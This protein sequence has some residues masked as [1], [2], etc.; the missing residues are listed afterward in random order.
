VANGL[1]RYNRGIFDE[2]YQPG[3]TGYE[4]EVAAVEQDALAQAERDREA[5]SE[6][7]KALRRGALGLRAD[8]AAFQAIPDLLVGD[9]EEAAED[10]GEAQ[11]LQAR[12]AQ[13]TPEVS[14][15]DDVNSVGDAA[16]LLVNTLAEQAPNLVGITTGAGALAVGARVGLRKTVRGVASEVTARTLPLATRLA[17][18]TATEASELAGTLAARKLAQERLTAAAGRG[19]L[20]VAYPTL[21]G[22]NLLAAAPDAEDPA[23]L[24]Q[25][26]GGALLTAAPQAI[27]ETAL[28]MRVLKNLGL[29]RGAEAAVRGAASPALLRRVATETA[30]GAL[31]EGTTELAQQA[32]QRGMRS[33]L[34]DNISAFDD[35]AL[36]EYLDSFVLGAIGGGGFGGLSVLGG[37][38]LDKVLG[39]RGSITERYE[40]IL[41][42]QE[43]TVRESQDQFSPGDVATILDRVLLPRSPL[44]QDTEL[45]RVLAEYASSP[46]RRVPDDIKFVKDLLRGQVRPEF[47]DKLDNIADLV[48][49]TSFDLYEGREDVDQEVEDTVFETEDPRA[50]GTREA[51]ER[52]IVGATRL[53]TDKNLPAG[54]RTGEVVELDAPLKD[55]LLQSVKL[56]NRIQELKGT[57]KKFD[58]AAVDRRVDEAVTEEERREGR[59][60]RDTSVGTRLDLANLNAQL[61]EATD[62]TKR[63]E[64]KAQI[65]ELAK[66]VPAEDQGVAARVEKI[67]GGDFIRGWARARGIE[68]QQAA[69]DFV[70]SKGADVQRVLKEDY[71]GDALKMLDDGH[72]EAVAIERSPL[73]EAPGVTPER[74]EEL[75]TKRAEFRSRNPAPQPGDISFKFRNKPVTIDFKELVADAMRNADLGRE[76]DNDFIV[77]LAD[78]VGEAMGNLATT[79]GIPN[80]D[81]KAILEKLPDNLVVL[82]RKG[83]GI[84]YGDLKEGVK[85]ASNADV[86]EDQATRRQIT[87]LQSQLE[88]L[89]QT[90]GNNAM[91]I[92]GIEVEIERLTEKLKAKPPIEKAQVSGEGIDSGEARREPMEERRGAARAVQG[93]RTTAEPILQEQPEQR[94]ENIDRRG[95]AK[96]TAKYLREAVAR[97]KKASR[98]PKLSDRERHDTEVKIEE[99]ERAIEAYGRESQDIIDDGPA[100]RTPASQNFVKNLRKYFDEISARFGLPKIRLITSRRE[101]RVTISSWSPGMRYASVRSASFPQ[102]S[103]RS[104]RRIGC[105]SAGQNAT[106]WPCQ[107]RGT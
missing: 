34:A 3:P 105:S 40:K 67:T 71:D 104:P 76:R 21:A 23:A 50:V 64:L 74:I 32:L 77:R 60:P 57:G 36:K 73:D 31:T 8:I 5:L 15:L 17:P 22:E 29:T 66:K 58:S 88:Q 106:T 69:T 25:A 81:L 54:Q 103:V 2:A 56:S 94:E 45:H 78:L 26:A 68:P 9:E 55:Q 63:A 43:G 96:E 1:R 35:E 4:E 46:Q 62:E 27:L 90:P 86:R 37:R 12:A 83:G 70:M 10:L 39:P 20:A 102:P 49:V 42:G 30:K 28:P 93:G 75:V 14:T 85:R 33:F 18:G 11:R 16:A 87:Q 19:A 82:G 107:G 52:E 7:G 79:A 6:P 72:F 89:R 97:L 98:D 59:A 99:L 65:D 101:M 38:G 80:T 41:A 84:T 61:A 47:K 51:G 95:E 24:R 44:R 53:A 91:R 92:A 48:S 13:F 100:A